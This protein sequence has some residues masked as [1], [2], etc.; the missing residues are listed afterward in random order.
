MTETEVID[1]IHKLPVSVQR[2]LY[3]YVDFLY[4]AY[5]QVPD[6]IK[7]SKPSKDFFDENELTEAGR[8]WLEKRAGQA[9]ANPEKQ[10][11]WRE[12]LN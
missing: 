8:L 2:H 10:K 12:F 5:S 4:T 7:G 6:D 1:K 11:P 9:L 3:L